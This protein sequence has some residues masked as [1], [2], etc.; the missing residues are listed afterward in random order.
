MEW[1]FSELLPDRSHARPALKR[2]L[3]NPLLFILLI[4]IQAYCPQ[5]T[6]GSTVRNERAIEHLQAV[7]LDDTLLHVVEQRQSDRL[8]WIRYD[9]HSMVPM[10]SVDIASTDSGDDLEYFFILRDTLYTLS[11]H[12]NNTEDCTEVF[13]MRYDTDGKALDSPTMVHKRSEPGQPRNSGIQYRMSPDSSHILL[14]FDTE[15]E[16]KKSEAI[17]FK[18]YS[19]HWVLEWEKEL[20]LPETPTVL[21]A[22]HYLIDNQ[23]GVYMMS[24][25]KPVKTSADWQH[26][27]GGQYEIYYYNFALN[28]LKQYEIS[29]KDKQ[30]IG[31]DFMLSE[32]Q[33]VIIAGFYSDNFQNK[34][35]GTI[36]FNIASGGGAIR[37]AAYTP[38]S[39]AFLKEITG[40]EKGALENFYPE[41]LYIHSSN[42]VVLAGEQYST[43]RYVYNDPTTGRQYVEYRYNYDDLLVCILDSA[44][45]HLHNIHVPKR[46][47]AANANDPNFSYA[48]AADEQGVSLTFN[49]ERANNESASNKKQR[50]IEMWTGRKTGVTTRVELDYAGT[51][52]RMT[53]ADNSTERLLFSP[54]M[55]PSHPWARSIAGFDDNRTYKFC[56]IH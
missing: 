30:V 33:D 13:A 45:K 2:L 20:R 53:L 52:R 23:G 28:K 6:C 15:G 5:L 38:F 31:V 17:H 42:H 51:M 4:S 49:D 9:L 47:Q 18:C 14:F 40:K 11:T 32:R 50:D 39:S 21:P 27:Q 37:T 3:Y 10:S 56:R 16:R 35:A 29:L 48:F 7:G 44:G 43:S 41:H 36:L 19:R 22:H 24:G 26:P 46:Q 12:W 8:R 54:L 55:Q 34:A 1:T 25:R